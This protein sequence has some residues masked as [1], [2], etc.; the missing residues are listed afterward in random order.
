MTGDM[1]D[2]LHIVCPHCGTVNRVSASKLNQ[3]G[4]CGRCR[5]MLFTGHPLELDGAG[6]EKQIQRSDVPVV[7]DFWAP[8]CG[9]CV[10]MAPFYEQAT[11]KLEPRVRLTKLNTEVEQGIAAQFGIRSI[12]TMIIF[13]TGQEVARQ[14][15]AMDLAN[16]IRWVNS[17]V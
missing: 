16:I 9:P 13:K 12:P 3:G 14:A 10:M 8:W 5:D 2:P 1:K 4:R 7:V 11:A 17:H 15:G 6:F